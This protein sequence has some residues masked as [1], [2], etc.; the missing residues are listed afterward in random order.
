MPSTVSY[1]VKHFPCMGKGCSPDTNACI[2]FIRCLLDLYSGCRCGK[3]V[4]W[5]ILIGTDVTS[6]IGLHDVGNIRPQKVETLL[7]CDMS[8]PTLFLF[9]L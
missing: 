1:Y 2:G 4:V 5:K 7:P 3:S 6:E 8:N 9:K